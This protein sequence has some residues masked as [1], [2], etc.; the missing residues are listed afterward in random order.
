MC[1]K[2]FDIIFFY[3]SCLYVGILDCGVVDIF[4]IIDDSGSVGRNYF[5][6]IKMFV[7]DVI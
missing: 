4:I 5:N 6:V 2:I 7:K 1:L 3:K